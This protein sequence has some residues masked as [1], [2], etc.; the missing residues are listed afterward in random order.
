MQV[1]GEMISR[2]NY[3]SRSSGM[4]ERQLEGNA[5]MIGGILANAETTARDAVRDVVNTTSGE[6][7]E[8]IENLREAVSTFR[9]TVGED[10]CGLKPPAGIGKKY[11]K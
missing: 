6:A 2:G 10:S 8:A 9:H 5:A 7:Y 1:C 11:R 3:G 4:R